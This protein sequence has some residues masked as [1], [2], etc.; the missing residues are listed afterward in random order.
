MPESLTAPPFGSCYSRLA[1]H[2]PTAHDLAIRLVKWLGETGPNVV[3][4]ISGVPLAALAV[5]FVHG[6]L[7]APY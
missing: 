4:R 7:H 3:G 6:G 2:V 1:S 5:Q